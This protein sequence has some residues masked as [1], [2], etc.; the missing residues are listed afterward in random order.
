M[1][2]QLENGLAPESSV[3]VS[4]RGPALQNP[5][6]RIDEMGDLVKDRAVLEGGGGRPMFLFSAYGKKQK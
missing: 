1:L 5:K 6:A 2:M 3:I 4:S